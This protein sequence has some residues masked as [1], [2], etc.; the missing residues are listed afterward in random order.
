MN[1]IK[2][3]KEIETDGLRAT[4]EGFDTAKADEERLVYFMCERME[5][6][7]EADA[8]ENDFRE[9]EWTIAQTRAELERIARKYSLEELEKL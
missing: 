1:K 7:E 5:T 2:I 8:R 4:R 9:A 6:Q 3:E